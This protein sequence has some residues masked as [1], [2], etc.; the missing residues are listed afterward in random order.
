MPTNTDPF[1]VR[2]N[3]IFWRGTELTVGKTKVVLGEEAVCERAMSGSQMTLDMLA[4]LLNHGYRAI[5]AL[6]APTDE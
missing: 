3:Q 1:F 5:R 6:D 4:Q 2:D